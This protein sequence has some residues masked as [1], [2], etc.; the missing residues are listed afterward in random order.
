M[1]IARRPAR[2]PAYQKICKGQYQK[3]RKVHANVLDSFEASQVPGNYK[4]SLQAKLLRG[5]QSQRWQHAQC[6]ALAV[7]PSDHQVPQAGPA[8]F[9]PL[10]SENPMDF[11]LRK[12]T[13][14]AVF[15][16]IVSLRDSSANPSFSVQSLL[17]RGW[18]G[19][20][21]GLPRRRQTASNFK[22][23]SSGKALGSPSD[24]L[25]NY[26]LVVWVG[27]CWKMRM[28]LVARDPLVD[29]LC[30]NDCLPAAEWYRSGKWRS[31]RS[32]DHDQLQ[33]QAKGCPMAWRCRCP[34]SV[35]IA[36]PICHFCALVQQAG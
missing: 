29:L 14:R 7:L 10:N 11:S 31:A 18:D 17:L 2:K 35:D 8:A 36:F 23:P 27:Y 3:T 5:D 13:D 9:K 30:L 15:L 26:V 20:K 32:T 24:E 6:P 12:A 4:N 16:A 33:I 28:S 1:K 21:K 34:C 25:T 19:K 22:R